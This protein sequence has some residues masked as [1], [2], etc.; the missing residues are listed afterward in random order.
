MIKYIIFLTLLL[1]CSIALSHDSNITYRD[2]ENG[3]SLGRSYVIFNEYQFGSSSTEYVSGSSTTNGGTSTMSAGIIY[4]IDLV[5]D[6]GFVF[7]NASGSTTVN[8]Y[9]FIG[10]ATSNFQ[11]NLL[12]FEMNGATNTVWSTDKDLEAMMV[13]VVCHNGTSN[14]SCGMTSIKDRK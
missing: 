14:F 11:A 13:G 7:K 8:I 1:N 5:G 6:K 3:L 4:T 9:G 10:S 2:I 12:S